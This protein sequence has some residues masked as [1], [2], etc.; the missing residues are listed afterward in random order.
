MSLHALRA[1]RARDEET[2]AV[3]LG[4]L[5]DRLVAMEKRCRELERTMHTESASYDAETKRGVSIAA[6]LEWH[7][8]WEACQAEL[9]R[10]RLAIASLEDEWRKTQA[11]LVQ[12][13]QERKVLD[14]LDERRRRARDQELRRREQRLL[15]DAAQRARVKPEGGLRS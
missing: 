10:T 3:A 2:I 11:W 9:R 1:L 12:T 7:G 5:T 15:D 14:R 8:R 13:R 4:H 6:A